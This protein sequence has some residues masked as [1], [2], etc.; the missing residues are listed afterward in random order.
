MLSEL[1][2]VLLVQLLS[3]GFLVSGRLLFDSLDALAGIEIF[4]IGVLE[5]EAHSLGEARCF[6]LQRGGNVLQSVGRSGK[7]LPKKPH[8]QPTPVSCC[9]KFLIR[10]L[11]RNFLFKGCDLSFS[12][13][14]W[15]SRCICHFSRR[16]GGGGGGGEQVLL[17]FVALRDQGACG[18]LRHCF[19][20][21]VVCGA[22]WL[23]IAYSHAHDQTAVHDFL[24]NT[25]RKNKSMDLYFL[26]IGSFET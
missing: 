13:S 17:F 25:S 7:E 20:M 8:H 23:S 4:L 12:E 11:R 3:T 16:G 10:S 26:A 19:S 22:C 24:S 9:G 6:S 2:S 1:L 21:G 18:A 15:L 14:P 5:V